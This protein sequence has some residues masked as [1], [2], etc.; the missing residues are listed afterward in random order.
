MSATAAAPVTDHDYRVQDDL[1][2][3]SLPQS[4]RDPTRKVAWTNAIC[5]AV[6]G[7]GV[8]FHAEARRFEF[9][10]EV[11]D[12]LPVEIPE[13]VP[14][15]TPPQT[16]DKPDEEPPDQ[17]NEA[18]AVPTVVVPDSAKVNY[19]VQVSGPTVVAKDFTYVPPPPRNPPKKLASAPTGPQMF[20]G[21]ASTDGGTYPD[22][23]YPRDALMRRE[24]GEV[25]LY[26]VV[27]EDG[28]PEKV[29]V[30]IS[31]GSPVL[32]RSSRQHVQKYWRWPA[33]PRREYLV[34]I[35]FVIR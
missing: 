25:Q 13:F 33:G 17:V 18:P 27:T 6:L 32:D 31:S 24:T 2:R 29:E 20:R 3:E 7:V 30:R 34:P 22:V 21:G 28:A 5:A 8:L 19:A 9:R 10:A 15:V 1:N 4:Q 26:V 35:E 23:P 12:S 14:E 11:V 16:Q